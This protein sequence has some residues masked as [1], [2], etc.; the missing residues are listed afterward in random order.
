MKCEKCG[1]E[2]NSNLGYCWVCHQKDIE[3]LKNSDV[4]CAADDCHN[5]LTDRQKLAGG[6]YC[7]VDCFHKMIKRSELEYH[8]NFNREFKEKIRGKFNYTCAICGKKENGPNHHVHHVNR[9]EKLKPPEECLF[10][11]LCPAC[12]M[13]SHK[14]YEKYYDYFISTYYK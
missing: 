11:I 1:R 3:H 5:L 14:Q 12:H 10:V 9:D 2:I 7:S 8:P 13:L 4:I 6:K